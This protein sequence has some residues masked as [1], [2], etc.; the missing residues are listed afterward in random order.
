MVQN[1]KKKK[2]TFL[3]AEITSP[4]NVVNNGE[5]QNYITQLKKKTFLYSQHHNLKQ[6]YSKQLHSKLPKH[7]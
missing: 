7:T 1:P 6:L 2:T 4:F 3:T 5:K